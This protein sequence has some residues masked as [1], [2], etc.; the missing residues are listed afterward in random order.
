MLF[1]FN[2]NP[3]ARTATIHRDAEDTLIIGG[4]M[5][6]Q[7]FEDQGQ[8]TQILAPVDPAHHN[9]NQLLLNRLAIRDTDGLDVISLRGG[10]GPSPALMLIGTQGRHGRI[11]VRNNQGGDT[12]V[13]R[14]QQGVIECPN[15]DTAEDFEVVDKREAEPGTVMV[16]NDGGQLCAS[17]QAYDK[18]VAG[19]LS[20]AE[21][22]RPGIILGR[23]KTS[24]NKMPLALNGRVYC[25]ADAQYGQV[26]VGDLLTTSPTLGHAMKVT[27]PTRAFGAVIGKALRPLL[28]GRG[29]IPI[30]V[31]LQ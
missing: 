15:C 20:G 11:A 26:E 3:D 10:V 2:E 18:R 22:M 30:L 9:Q 7:N 31:A 19:V 8:R 6:I 23:S 25:K 16:I 29:L 12:I 27:D 4:T 28:D 14:G 21:D 5:A 17:S 13:L 1:D 24:N